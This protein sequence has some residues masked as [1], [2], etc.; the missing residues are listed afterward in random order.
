VPTLM[1]VLGELFHRMGHVRNFPPRLMTTHCVRLP[2][3]L[4]PRLDVRT[5]PD[6]PFPPAGFDKD[7]AYYALN[8]CRGNQKREDTT[9]LVV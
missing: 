2:A 7:G 6:V 4:Q 8:R 9:R 5:E 3:D 1:Q